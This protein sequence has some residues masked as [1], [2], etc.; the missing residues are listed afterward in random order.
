MLRNISTPILAGLLAL[1]PSAKAE[2]WVTP[3]LPVIPSAIYNITNYGA[4]GNG[5]ATNTDAIQAAIDAASK[6][7]GGTVVI[8]AGH[9]LSGPV[10][11][12]SQIDLQIDGTLLMLPFDKYPGGT[13]NPG[14]L[15][16]GA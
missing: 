9:Y 7:G 4:L 14:N 5:I 12:A 13:E 11:L 8:P 10:R 1:V 3:A 16:G 6:A 2:T 15:I